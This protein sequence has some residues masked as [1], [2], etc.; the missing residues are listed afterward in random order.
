MRQLFVF[1]T[2]DVDGRVGEVACVTSSEA[3]ARAMLGAEGY[4]G[5]LLGAAPLGGVMQFAGS[6]RVTTADVGG[7]D[8]QATVVGP[9]NPS[10]PGPT[11]SAELDD[12]PGGVAVAERREA[13]FVAGPA[14]G[15]LESTVALDAVARDYALVSLYMVGLD[16]A[17]IARAV[18]VTPRIAAHRIG[19]HLL[20]VPDDGV[21]AANE[22]P[23]VLEPDSA[24]DVVDD[25]YLNGMSVFEISEAI[26]RPTSDVV[27]A[28]LDAPSRVVAVTRAV[29]QALRSDLEVLKGAAAAAK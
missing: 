27:W 11:P 25:M 23:M 15:R 28:L 9:A 3:D 10:H 4:D 24:F 18:T 29:L 16:V 20:G 7:D 5:V 6:S 13:D 17:S 12:A 14:M 8:E 21:D 1:E 19:F 22:S 26:A 2:V